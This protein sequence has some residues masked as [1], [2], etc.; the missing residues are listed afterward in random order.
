[1]SFSADVVKVDMTGD[2]IA[3]FFE[4][5]IDLYQQL[6][7]K[8]KDYVTVSSQRAYD[9]SNIIEKISES[10]NISMTDYYVSEDGFNVWVTDLD[11]PINTPLDEIPFID[12]NYYTLRGTT[13]IGVYDE[14]KKYKSW[15][16]K[17]NKSYI[18][19]AKDW[20]KA[21]SFFPKS[22]KIHEYVDQD[23]IIFNSY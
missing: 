21:L 20:K 2:K 8:Y 23:L 9:T 1:M 17:T 4:S 13:A 15:V 14:P 12:E 6:Y 16:Y 11:K 19:D 22:H 3:G 10:H 7:D 5:E 18:I